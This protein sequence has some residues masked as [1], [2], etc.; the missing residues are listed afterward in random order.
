M[1][2][3]PDKGAPGFFFGKT[4][5]QVAPNITKVFQTVCW[6][7]K[8]LKL[9]KSDSKFSCVGDEGVCTNWCKPD[10]LM[11]EIMVVILKLTSANHKENFFRTFS[12]SRSPQKMIRSWSFD[13]L[14]NEIKF[15]KFQGPRIFA[16]SGKIAH[17]HLAGTS[18]G[19]RLNQFIF[20]W[21]GKLSG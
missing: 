20:W 17:L 2:K 15:P 6:V 5:E 4:K 3:E 12:N 11:I 1:K 19:S 9:G 21:D 8:Q 10:T 13:P 14:S 16:Q 18:T 7:L